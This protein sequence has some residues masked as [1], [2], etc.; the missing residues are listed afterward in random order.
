ML[1]GGKKSGR[2]GGGGGKEKG[3]DVRNMGNKKVR[4]LEDSTGA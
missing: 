4:R 3:T 1:K 2:I